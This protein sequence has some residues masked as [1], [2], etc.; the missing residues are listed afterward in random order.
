MAY[1][2]RVAMGIY[3]GDEEFE[4][5]DVLAVLAPSGLVESM[6]VGQKS[7]CHQLSEKP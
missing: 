7:S 4:D 2:E 1:M 3:V 6:V 5:E